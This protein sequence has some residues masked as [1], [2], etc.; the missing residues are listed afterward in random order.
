MPIGMRAYG[1]PTH[2][3]LA[4]QNDDKVCQTVN[5]M[6]FLSIQPLDLLT[7]FS[8]ICWP[9][10]IAP[11]EH[12]HIYQGVYNPTDIPTLRKMSIV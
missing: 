12:A 10:T 6:C 8:S 4:Y 7:Y 1:R 3:V 5:H 2:H 9:C 11:L